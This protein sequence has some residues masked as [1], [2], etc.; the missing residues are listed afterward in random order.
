MRIQ[1]LSDLHLE[2]REN[3]D[4]LRHHLPPVTG[5]ILIVAG[6]CCCLDGTQRFPTDPLQ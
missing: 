2:F 5:D 6:D 1:Y 4:Y 3:A